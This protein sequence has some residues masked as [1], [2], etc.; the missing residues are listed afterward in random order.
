MARFHCCM[1]NNINSMLFEIIIYAILIGKI[2]LATWRK[3]YTIFL[4]QKTLTYITSDKTVS[5]G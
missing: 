5:T 2:Q 3:Q 4:Y 1:N